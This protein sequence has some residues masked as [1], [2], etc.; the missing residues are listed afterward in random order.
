MLTHFTERDI[1]AFR[2]LLA[3]FVAAIRATSPDP[4]SHAPQHVE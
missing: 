4:L 1:K 2:A 3:K